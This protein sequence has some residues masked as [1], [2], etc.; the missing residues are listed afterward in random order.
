MGFVAEFR[1]EIPP[2][3]AASRAVPDVWFS[4]EDVVLGDG[5]AHKFL[6]AAHGDRFRALEAALDGD[7]TV[8]EYVHL[9]H[10]EGTAYYSVTYDE[11]ADTRGTYQVAV[12]ADIAYTDVRLQDGEYR[13]R[14]RSPDRDALA[15]LRDDCRERDTPFRPERLQ[16][17]AEGESSAVAALTES[18]REALAHERGYFATPREV[19]LA[20]L[21]DELGISRQAVAERLRRGHERLLAAT[22]E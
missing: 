6:V 15:T 18:Q 11:A 21:A 16:E 20:D 13:I 3:V 4:G 8:A 22:F 2:V 7:P 1:V 19:A 9:W 17:A 10:R 12:E 5:N 14:A